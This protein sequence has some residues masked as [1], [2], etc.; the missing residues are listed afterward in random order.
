VPPDEPASATF[1]IA[2]P[3]FHSTFVCED[4]AEA[5]E[6]LTRLFGVRARQP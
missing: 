1:E 3:I 5:Q 2:A 6:T 4:F